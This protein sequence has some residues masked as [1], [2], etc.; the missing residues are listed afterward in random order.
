[1][2]PRSAGRAIAEV[3][4]RSLDGC[5]KFIISSLC[6]GRHVKPFSPAAF[7]V[8]TTNPHWARLVG[9]VPFYLCVIH[10]EGLWPSSDIK[11]IRFP[12][13]VPMYA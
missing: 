2:A 3:K 1:M 4:Q 8:V 9:Y 6:F 7:T 13:S 12:L 11:Q 10:R 5:P